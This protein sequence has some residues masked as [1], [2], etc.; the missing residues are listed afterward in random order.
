[1]NDRLPV[2]VSGPKMLPT[3]AARSKRAA[4]DRCVAGENSI[5]VHRGLRYPQQVDQARLPAILRGG[6]RAVRGRLF[7]ELNRDSRGFFGAAS[8]FFNSYSKPLG[9][10]VD[11]KLNFLSLRHSVA[12]AFGRGGYRTKSSMCLLGHRDDDN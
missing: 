2:T 10:K 12:D 4:A 1:M 11:K 5:G 8:R 3:G 7:P 6:V 9:V